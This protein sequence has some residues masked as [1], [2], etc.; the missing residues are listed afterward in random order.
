MVTLLDE[1]LS[2]HT[3]SEVALLLDH[4]EVGDTMRWAGSSQRVVV[5]DAGLRVEAW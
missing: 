4:W 5:N 2:D 1:F 3:A